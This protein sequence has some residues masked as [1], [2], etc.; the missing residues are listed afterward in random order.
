MNN[1]QKITPAKII[2]EQEQLKVKYEQEIEAIQQENLGLKNTITKK[3]DEIFELQ[4]TNKNLA[5]DR[6]D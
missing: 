5:Q 4:K 3:N 6:D 2:E 1:Q